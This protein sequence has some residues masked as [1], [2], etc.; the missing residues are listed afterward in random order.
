MFSF[1]QEGCRAQNIIVLNAIRNLVLHWYI[2]DSRIAELVNSK[3]ENDILELSII[4]CGA[5]C[6]LWSF[7][8]I[9]LEKDTEEEYKCI[10][11]ESC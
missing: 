2:M 9:S 4:R 5:R 10:D 8:C 6:S 11:A 7:K 1:L 3:F